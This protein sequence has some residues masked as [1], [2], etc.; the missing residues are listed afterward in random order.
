MNDSDSFRATG[1]RPGKYEMTAGVE[2]EG[3]EANV[4]DSF[5][6]LVS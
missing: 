3:E 2:R 5:V 4:G 1:I 6:E